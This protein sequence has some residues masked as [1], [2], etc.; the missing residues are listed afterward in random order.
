MAD[1]EKELVSR[2]L[3][4]QASRFVK[5][6]RWAEAEAAFL[7]SGKLNPSSLAWLGAA[8]AA[9]RRQRFAQAAV[10]VEWALQAIP[11]RDT[12]EV[13]AGVAQFQAHD[14]DGVEESF[15]RLLDAPPIDTPIYLFLCL[16][17]INLGRIEEA[18]EQLMAGW[19]QEWA[20]AAAS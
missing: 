1:S 17:L 14:W 2:K 6:E 13:Q 20:D 18:G 16:A 19:K 11:I 15:R 3:F 12:P 4:S 9:W 5:E 10:C 7:E 8:I